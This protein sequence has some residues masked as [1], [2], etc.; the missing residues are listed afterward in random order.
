MLLTANPK[1]ASSSGSAQVFLQV[2][3]KGDI[4]SPLTVG[5]LYGHRVL[6]IGSPRVSG[7][8]AVCGIQVG[9]MSSVWKWTSRL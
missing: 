8:L 9:R 7:A 5:S 4:G 2:H 1:V 3:L 6:A